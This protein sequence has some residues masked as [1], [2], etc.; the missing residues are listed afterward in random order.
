MIHTGTGNRVKVSSW[1]QLTE[2]MNIVFLQS[3]PIVYMKYM[4]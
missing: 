4:V 3:F 2:K 1:K